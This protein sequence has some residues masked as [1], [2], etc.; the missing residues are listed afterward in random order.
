VFDRS[1]HATVW[2]DRAREQL[3]VTEGAI[4]PPFVELAVPLPLPPEGIIAREYEAIVRGGGWHLDLAGEAT[5]QDPLTAVRT[6]AIGL[7]LWNG[8]TAATAIPRVTGRLRI[9][10]VSQQKFGQDRQVLLR[11]VPEAEDFLRAK[12][13]PRSG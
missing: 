3:H 12:R 1:D 9:T 6:W 5:R 7:L 10:E 13:A 8:E 11:R 2:F 4:N